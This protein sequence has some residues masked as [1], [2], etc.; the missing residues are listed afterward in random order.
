MAEP[1]VITIAKKEFFDHLRSRKFL[2]VFG[3]FLVIA[4]V[5]TINGVSS[6]NNAIQSYS[7]LQQ[8]ISLS[9]IPAADIPQYLGSPPSI[10]LIYHVM[11][12]CLLTV[13]AILGIAMGFDLL[14]K[15]KES[16]SLKILLAHPI[17]RDEVINGKALGGITAIALALGIVF[18]LNSSIL[19]IFG[20]APNASEV[21][22]LVI[23]G[24]VSFIY[25]FTYFAIALCIS[26]ISDESGSALIYILVIY[27]VLSLLVPV[28]MSES[29]MNAITG[30]PPEMPKTL[31]DHL[32]GSSGNTTDYLS[33]TSSSPE[34]EEYQRGVDE[35]SKRQSA[36]FDMFSLITPN[37][38]YE[39]ISLAI[40]MPQLANK[41]YSRAETS[42][43]KDGFTTSSMNSG[44]SVIDI[45]GLVWKNILAL[46]IFPSIF[47][48][49][50]YVSF[51]RL[52]IR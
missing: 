38:N 19:L 42:S 45:L 1:N 43:N 33:I 51:M 21:F 13:G 11:S 48:G 47:F 6:Y 2:L 30:T 10:L 49:L 24:F 7:E 46:L 17:Y 52:D 31:S 40:T 26:S 25:I 32:A 27:I 9:D 39:K 14:S 41:I 8:Q 5:G 22:L 28:L 34:F 36:L 37:L 16:K 29:C 18:V 23:F 15:E 4:I 20:I 44:E 3:I 12:L 50:A 35:Y